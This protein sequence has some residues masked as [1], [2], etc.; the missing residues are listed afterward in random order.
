MS[1]TKPEVEIASERK[2]M[3]TRFHELA[4]IQSILR[5]SILITL[6]DMLTSSNVWSLLLHSFTTFATAQM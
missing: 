5:R 1:A 6:F 2:D 4:R 3:A